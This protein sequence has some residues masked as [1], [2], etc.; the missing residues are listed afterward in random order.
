[1][2]SIRKLIVPTL[3]QPA[4]RYS[5][6]AAAKGTESSHKCCKPGHGFE[7]RLKLKRIE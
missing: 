6:L 7:P 3:P 2:I 4:R 5:F 1:M